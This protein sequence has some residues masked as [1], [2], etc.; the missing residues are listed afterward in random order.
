MFF[1]G[2]SGIL[3]TNAHSDIKFK[4]TCAIAPSTSVSRGGGGADNGV[5]EESTA[6]KYFFVIDHNAFRR[7]LATNFT[8]V[9]L[10]QV[11][12]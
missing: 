7:H 5:K 8:Q 12:L 2:I 3:V 1:N 9:L 6:D 11:D 10:L 4:W